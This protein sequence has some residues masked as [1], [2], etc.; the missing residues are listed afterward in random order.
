MPGGRKADWKKEMIHQNNSPTPAQDIDD[1]LARLQRGDLPIRDAEQAVKQLHNA[2]QDVVSRLLVLMDDPLPDQRATAAILLSATSDAS[3]VPTLRKHIK[4]PTVDDTAKIK[5][6]TITAQLDSEIDVDTLLTHLRDPHTAL[7]MARREHLQLLQSPR[8]L[9]LWLESVE[10]ELE[11]D[12]RIQLIDNSI[13]L[14]DPA[15]V[16]MLV[17]LCYDPDDDVALAAMDAVERFK[18]IRAL[19]PLKEL[20]VYHARPAIRTEAQKTVDRLLVRAA[21]VEQMPPEPIAPVHACYLTPIDGAGGQAALIVRRSPADRFTVLSVLFDDRQGIHLCNGVTNMR[22]CEFDDLLQEYAV[23]STVL[24]PVTHPACLSALSLAVDTTWRVVGSLPMSYLAWRERIEFGRS[25]D[26]VLPAAGTIPP[27][28]RQEL[29]THCYELLFQ[30]EFRFWLFL[31]AEIQDLRASYV[32]RAR[33]TDT[34]LDRHTLRELLRQSVRDTV[35]DPRRSLI[36]GRLQRMAPLLR[37]LY[38]DDEVWQWAVIAAEALAADSPL[39]LQEHPFLLGMLA[40]SLENAIGAPVG[41][42]DG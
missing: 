22:R 1:I 16:P 41:W 8:D 17:C 19:L 36:Q 40:Y 35:T 9:V 28:R 24:V 32:E 13:E 6:V 7:R 11:P 37:T 30:D 42:F 21:L 26:R 14:G 23:Q 5:L 20:A 31:P 15:A 18:D 38:K 39:P 25:P 3:I 12:L 27:Q 33:H 2:G 29:L 10:T 34:L 4:D